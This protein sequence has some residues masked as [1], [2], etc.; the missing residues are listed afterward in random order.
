M[1]ELAKNT[2]DITAVPVEEKLTP[3][4]KEA[5]L[6]F[7]KNRLALIGLAIVI[8][9]IILAIIAPMIAPYSFKEQ[10]LA[11]RLQGPSSKHWF[12]T[13][14]F[15]RDILSRIIYGSRISLWVGFF[16]V[17]GSVIVGTLLRDCRRVLR[18]LGRYR[19][20]PYFRYHAGIS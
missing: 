2:A 13:D 17:L 4:W 10:V 16:S 18:P 9:F 15:G 3:P 19:Y 20:F 6:T 14:D 7:C 11:E 1:A 12:G 8:F 5:W